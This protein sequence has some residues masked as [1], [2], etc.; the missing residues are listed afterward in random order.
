MY[1]EYSEV[2]LNHLKRLLKKSFDK[3]A[4]LNAKILKTDLDKR[5]KSKE[6]IKKLEDRIRYMI[7]SNHWEYFTFPDGKTFYPLDDLVKYYKDINAS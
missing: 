1:T 3:I 7:S 2:D 6:E 5:N 4:N